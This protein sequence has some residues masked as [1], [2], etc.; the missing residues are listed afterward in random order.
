MTTAQARFIFFETA[1]YF[2][3][4]LAKQEDYIVFLKR[5][6]NPR[7]DE[8]EKEEQ[9]VPRYFFYKHKFDMLKDCVYLEEDNYEINVFDLP[10]EAFKT[11]S[12]FIHPILQSE[13]DLVKKVLHYCAIHKTLRCFCKE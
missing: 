7:Q 3:D 6:L 11:P 1:K 13:L 12:D 2:A 9:K 10:L 4:L 5:Q 8:I